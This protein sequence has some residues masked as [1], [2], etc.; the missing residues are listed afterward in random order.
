MMT[1]EERKRKIEIYNQN[2]DNRPFVHCEW[3]GV[4]HIDN[5][6]K[7]II[8]ENY[9]ERDRIDSVIV[10][11]AEDGTGYILLVAVNRGDVGSA[12][13]DERYFIDGAPNE[14]LEQKIEEANARL[15]ALQRQL[16][17]RKEDTLTSGTL[18]RRGII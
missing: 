18:K 11:S 2:Y 6:A 9:S 13:V 3:S 17:H 12:T 1:A 8:D 5:V 7:A 16:L 4:Q 15:I 10:E 14:I